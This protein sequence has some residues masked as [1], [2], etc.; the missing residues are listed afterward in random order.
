MRVGSDTDK[1]PRRVKERGAFAILDYLK[2]QGFEGAF[3]RL[4]L[5]LSPTL[6]LGELREIRAHAEAL[7]R[8]ESSTGFR[9]TKRMSLMR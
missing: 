3:F 4:M 2:A 1:L 9:E 8:F 7:G 5:E 6:D